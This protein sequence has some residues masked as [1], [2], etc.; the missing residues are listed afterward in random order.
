ML[1]DSL[2]ND[3]CRAADAA[4]RRR[5][6]AARRRVGGE[7]DQQDREGEV[8]PQGR[9][10]RPRVEWAGRLSGSTQRHKPSGQRGDRCP[11]LRRQSGRDRYL[12]SRLINGCRSAARHHHRGIG[13]AGRSHRTAVVGALLGTVVPRAAHRHRRLAHA[14]EVNHQ[15][16]RAGEEQRQRQERCEG[17]IGERMEHG[18][19][20]PTQDRA[21]LLRLPLK[22]MS[23]H[24]LQ[25][26]R[27]VRSRSSPSHLSSDKGYGDLRGHTGIPLQQGE[28][29]VEAAALR[30]HTEATQ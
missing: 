9:V 14:A 23:G 22:L 30:E 16:G 26:T 29:G 4:H 3:D 7:S 13:R 28:V 2:E 15:R 10:R 18:V 5:A 11:E 12:L 8:R 1:I 17:A 24:A 6:S 21:G 20:Q 19:K 27:P 25:G